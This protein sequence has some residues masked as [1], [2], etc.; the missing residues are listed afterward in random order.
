MSSFEIMK[1][2]VLG[3]YKLLDLKFEILWPIRAI[4]KPPCH[5]NYIIITIFYL[6][7]LA[8]V[9]ERK[10]SVGSYI[11]NNWKFFPAN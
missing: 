7:V 9:Y 11:W 5:E 8:L 2:D 6:A 4:F 10:I 3:K 1:S